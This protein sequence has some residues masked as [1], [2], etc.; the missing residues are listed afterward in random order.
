MW[1]SG[2]LSK[3][4]FKNDFKIV[5]GAVFLGMNTKA[6][7]TNGSLNYTWYV[8]FC[9]FNSEMPAEHEKSSEHSTKNTTAAATT[10]TNKLWRSNYNKINGWQITWRFRSKRWLRQDEDRMNII[11]NHVA[12]VKIIH[13]TATT[14]MRF[15]RQ[16]REWQ[17]GTSSLSPMAEHSS[18]RRYRSRRT[19]KG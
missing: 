6:M 15:F 13:R 2:D 10:A 16:L 19:G 14:G 17:G 18:T 12:I 4:Y 8:L 11:N 1:A 7:Y 9:S 5:Q 3:K